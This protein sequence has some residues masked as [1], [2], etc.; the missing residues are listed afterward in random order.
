[1]KDHKQ[2]TL[3]I[4]DK[5]KVQRVVFNKSVKP[6]NIKLIKDPTINK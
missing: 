3:S 5:N 6:L 2:F 1:M 4:K